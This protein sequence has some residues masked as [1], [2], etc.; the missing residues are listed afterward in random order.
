MFKKK[1]LTVILALVVVFSMLAACSNNSGTKGNEVTPTNSNNTTVTPSNTNTEDGNEVS[2]L[3]H[4]DLVMA[5]PIIGAIPKDFDLIEAEINKITEAK[6]NT[7]VEILPIGVGN[8]IEQLNLKFSSGEKFDL[9]FMFGGVGLYGPNAAS[10]K[11]LALDEVLEEHGQGIIEVVG[12]DYIRAPQI[13]GKLYAV[14]TVG[15]FG[16]GAG[17]YMRKDIVDKHNIDIS[18]IKTLEDIGKVLETVKQN[19]PDIIPLGLTFGMGPVSTMTDYDNLTD[20]YGILPFSSSD[21]TIVNWYETEAFKQRS[22]LVHEW[23]KAGFIN[24]DAATTTVLPAD[25]VAGGRTFSYFSPSNPFTAAD[26]SRNIGTEIVGVEILQPSVSTSSVMNGLWTIAQQSEDPARAMMF[27]EMMYTDKE[28]VNL[29]A[30]GIEGT[31]YVKVSDTQV[32]FAEGLNAQNSGYYMYSNAWMLGN[33]RYAYLS[34]EE[35]PNKWEVAVQ[36]MANA[37]PS[38]ALGFTFD[39]EPVKNEKIALQNVNDKYYGLLMT[40]SINPADK[41]PDL[42]AELKK[43]GLDKYIEEKQRQ[44]DAWLAAQ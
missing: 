39:V 2:E 5:I 30:W 38:P 16:S 23:F 6:I 1:S 19:E 33:P 36:W 40:G 31:H 27:L 8:Y 14:P 42:L 3:E 12:A 17:Y 24:K 13:N 26:A 20:G 9:S 43:A 28:I 32:D 25:Q 18:S 10:G 11:Y 37:K 41:L 4:Y 15:T 35:D 34:K 44:F 29:L 21:T 22:A 7:T